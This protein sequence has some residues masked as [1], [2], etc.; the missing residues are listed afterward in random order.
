MTARAILLV[1]IALAPVVTLPASAAEHRMT[2]ACAERDLK[3]VALIESGGEAGAP[4][5]VLGQAGL[6]QMEARIA[7][8]AGR[9]YE[10]LALYGGLLRGLSRALGYASR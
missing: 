5:M 3:V 10:A 9:E 8:L 4:S 7:C 1:L 2:P 6:L